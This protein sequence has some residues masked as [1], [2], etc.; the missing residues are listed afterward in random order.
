MSTARHFMIFIRLTSEVD[1]LI[2][3][4]REGLG[5]WLSP[6]PLRTSRTLS[7]SF[8]TVYGRRLL[9]GTVNS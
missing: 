2:N 1:V 5:S 3:L 9:P 7:V 6:F 8:L 4:E